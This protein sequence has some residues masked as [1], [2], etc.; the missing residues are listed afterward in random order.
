VDEVFHCAATTRFDLPLA[1]SDRIN[2]AGTMAVHAFAVEAAA[3]GAFRRLHHVSTAYAAGCRRGV[4]GAEALPPDHA[5]HFRNTYER[6]KAR[7]ERFLRAAHEVPT[8]VYRPSIIVGDSRDGR[9]SS[10]NVVYFPMRLMATGRLPVAP[11][12]GRALLDCVPVDYVVDGICALGRREDSVGRTFHLT[13]GAQALRVGEVVAHTYAG[14]ARHKGQP[15]RV[16]TRTV[17]PVRWWLL[18][19]IFRLLARGKGRDLLARFSPY[20][21]YTRIDTVF[22]NRREV[23]LLT[24]AGVRTPAPAD[25]FPRIVD[26]ALR[27]D[28]GRRPAPAAERSWARV[29]LHPAASPAWER[30]S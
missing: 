19:R 17:G 9:T 12:G 16:G 7:A 30:T 11:Q 20:V 3:T 4:A 1:E 14:I 24:A 5:C 6:T 13:T 8:T 29:G 2:V 28:F 23:A 25:F 27:H 15:L 21:P 22:D 10:W 26:Y 18:E